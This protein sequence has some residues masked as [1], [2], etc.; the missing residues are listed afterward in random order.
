[1]HSRS[2]TRFES[3]SLVPS[4]ENLLLGMNSCKTEGNAAVPLLLFLGF[5]LPGGLPLCACLTPSLGCSTR[6]A[7]HSIAS[8]IQGVSSSSA[9]GHTN[10]KACATGMRLYFP[11]QMHS[12]RPSGKQ[13]SLS[14]A[15]LQ[16]RLLSSYWP[17]LL[18][19]HGKEPTASQRQV[20][21][22]Y[23]RGDWLVAQRACRAQ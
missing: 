19:T 12:C 2:D 11:F 23:L 3:E 6:P 20:P 13:G 1:M 21:A 7:G 17:P 14:I 9:A 8:N 10:G 22:A 15:S 18:A 5:N 16:P 4:G